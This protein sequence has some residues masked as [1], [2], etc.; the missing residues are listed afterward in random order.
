MYEICFGR[1]LL[2]GSAISAGCGYRKYWYQYRY[3]CRLLTQSPTVRMK[4]IFPID[5]NPMRRKH[6]L[7]IGGK[8]FASSPA[9]LRRI[10]SEFHK[11]SQI[12]SEEGY[13]SIV[14][15][16]K[17]FS[18]KVRKALFSI[19]K[20]YVYEMKLD[21][22]I[23]IPV[24]NAKI[25]GLNVRPI[26]LPISLEEYEYLGKSNANF[27]KIESA[28]EYRKSLKDG[29][30]VFLTYKGQTLMNRTGMT[31]YKNGA[32]SNC[33]PDELGREGAV[34]AGF[35]ETTKKARMMGIYSFVHSHIYRYLKE[36]GF[37]KVILLE[38]EEQP[39]P[40]KVQDRL[41]AKIIRSVHCVRFFIL[42]NYWLIHKD[43]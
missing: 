32:Y 27:E 42:F 15:A 37:K 41:G 22:K 26:F 19:E 21:N 10:S 36:M 1:R 16:I 14:W 13:P 8:M 7:H 39:G 20:F 40:I 18:F 38:S 17:D 31:L 43:A 4:W 30:I 11:Y 28:C 25:D 12:F 24:L 3:S 35:S 5:I 6:I 33:C 2:T 9:K 34:F 23:E 29:T